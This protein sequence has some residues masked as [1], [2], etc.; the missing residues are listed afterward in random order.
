MRV[1]FL[2]TGTS[3]GVPL[4]GCN[5][6]V[7]K[8]TNPK[9]NRL[10]SSIHIQSETTSVIIDTGPDFRQQMLRNIRAYNFI[11]KKEMELYANLHTQEQLKREF[12]Y[13]FSEQTYPGIPR[14]QL[15]TIDPNT[16]FTIGDLHFTPIQVLHFQLPVLGFRVNNFTYITDANFINPQ[17]LEKIKG[18]DVLVLN[19]LRH[20]KHIS[21]FSLEEAKLI[22][23]N[24][25]IQKTYF[26]HISHQLGCHDIVSESL[27]PQFELAYDGLTIELKNKGLNERTQM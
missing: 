2:G 8:S 5:C 20:E 6:D 1:T 17:E 24:L 13:I 18:S 15:H 16:N 4:I 21:H 7:C 12:H 19:A 23:N 22:A 9:D 10:R 3:Q 11:L 27:E 25:Q 26:T 14:V